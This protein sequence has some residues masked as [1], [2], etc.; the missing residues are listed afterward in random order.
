MRSPF[1]NRKGP[2]DPEF[3]GVRLPD[4]ESESLAELY[5]ENT[6]LTRYSGM[7]LGANIEMITHNRRMLEAL[8]HPFKRYAGYP[9]IP[10]PRDLALPTATLADAIAQRVSVRE[11]ATC[12]PTPLTALSALLLLGCGLKCNLQGLPAGGATW[13]TY[14]SG[15]ALFP[16][17]IYL[18]AFQVSDLSAGLY[19]YQVCDHCLEQLGD[20]V[21]A[22]AVFD[23][24]PQNDAIAAAHFALLVT[25]VFPRTT[26]KYG[27]RGYRFALLEAGHLLQNMYLLANPLHLG[28]VALGGF[29]DDEIHAAIG[30]DGTDEAVVYAALGGVPVTQLQMLGE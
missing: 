1:L 19:H 18:V 10:L 20:E 12:E 23:S 25:S 5:H 3:A 7:L 8:E 26:I 24:L 28:L 2:M 21:S 16:S 15:G 17:E 6:K 30:L 11:F 22:K 13:R 9:R 29:Y 4:R 27:E 14:P